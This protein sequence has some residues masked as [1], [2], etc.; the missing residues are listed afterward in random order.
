ME[1]EVVK[2]L[3]ECPGYWLL[4]LNVFWGIVVAASA[5]GAAYYYSQKK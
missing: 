5:I 4:V 2:S 1:Q 3:S